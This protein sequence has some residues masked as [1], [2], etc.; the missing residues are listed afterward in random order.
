MF[1]FSLRLHVHLVHSR[2]FRRLRRSRS[3]CT[4]LLFLSLGLITSAWFRVGAVWCDDFIVIL[5]KNPDVSHSYFLLL[6]FGVIIVTVTNVAFTSELILFILSSALL[7]LFLRSG[8]LLSI[9]ITGVA[10]MS[11]H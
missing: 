4:W 9:I 3:W 6:S 10:M 5:S 7:S 1:N 8:Y 2:S 11:Q